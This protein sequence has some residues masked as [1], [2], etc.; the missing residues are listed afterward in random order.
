MQI[1]KMNKLKIGVLAL[2]ITPSMGML[3]LINIAASKSFMAFVAVIFG[4]NF[5]YDVSK[6][7]V[8]STIK[9][10][11]Q[12]VTLAKHFSIA[13]GLFVLSF[14]GIYVEVSGNLLPYLGLGLVWLPSYIASLYFF[15][16]AER[17]YRLSVGKC[18]RK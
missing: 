2:W 1:S 11:E 12:W 9:E 13:I 16:E 14:I 15:A 7:I 5:V 18:V 17:T 10:K 6:R 4:C 8:N 3:F